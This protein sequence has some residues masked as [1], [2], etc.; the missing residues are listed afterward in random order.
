MSLLVLLGLFACTGEEASLPEPVAPPAVVVVL[1]DGL[2]PDH[3]GLYGSSRDT[4]PVLDAW[5]EGATRFTV[6]RSPAPAT[7]PSVKSLLA[8]DEVDD[9]V[10]VEHLAHRLVAA[11]WDARLLAGNLFL[12][13]AFGFGEGWTTVEHRELVPAAEQVARTVE[14]LEA[15]ERPTFL[16]VHLTDLLLP[17]PWDTEFHGL[18][19]EDAPTE[20]LA[21]DLPELSLRVDAAREALSDEEAQFLR[22]RYDQSIRAVDV[23]LQPL[24]EALGPADTLALTADHGTAFGQRGQVG[25]GLHLSEEQVRIPL[26]VKGPGFESSEVDTPVMLADLGATVLALAGAELPEQPAG[27]DLRTATS[28]SWQTRPQRLGHTLYGPARVGLVVGA[29]TQVMGEGQGRADWSGADRVAWSEATGEQT[30]RVWHLQVQPWDASLEP[31]TWKGATEVVVRHPKGF[32]DLWAPPMP[33]HSAPW[34]FEATETEVRISSAN[35]RLPRELLLQPGSPADLEGL[36]VSIVVDGERYTTRWAPKTDGPAR[37]EGGVPQLVVGPEGRELSLSVR[38]A[39][40]PPS[41][42]DKADEAHDEAS[43]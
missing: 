30:R 1:V 3:L 41:S 21:N 31:L 39:P 27:Q 37:V 17:N 26:V 22:G 32:V 23:A 43:G 9:F 15:R 13:E 14:I 19:V 36:E 16:L 38:W 5:A 20:R 34:G 12:T 7:V 35:G 33:I 8:A 11:G 10:P 2:G 40:P 4:S 18:F 25:F 24:L 29:E 28:A 42:Q 6:A